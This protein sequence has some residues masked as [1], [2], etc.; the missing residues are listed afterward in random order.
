MKRFFSWLLV[1]LVITPPSR[2]F[3]ADAD[4]YTATFRN[5]RAVAR[6]R[7]RGDRSVTIAMT[8]TGLYPIAEA[9]GSAQ[10]NGGSIAEAR[11]HSGEYAGLLANYDRLGNRSPASKEAGKALHCFWN[12]DYSGA[13]ARLQT[14]QE[15][16][17]ESAFLG[18]YSALALARVGRPAEAQEALTAAVQLEIR[19]PVPDW[20]R[21]M[22]RIQGR[23]R[24]WLEAA[25]SAAG[26]GQYV[27]RVEVNGAVR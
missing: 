5:G 10:D 3:S 2:A 14:A 4:V 11:G 26:L 1:V 24:S 23:E 19:H 16:D 13:V 7:A 22:E 21:L 9:I 27:R 6:A 8:R 20:Y 17:P 25:R 12:G 15:L 18:Y